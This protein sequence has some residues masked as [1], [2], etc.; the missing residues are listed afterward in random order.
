MIGS[1]PGGAIPL[2]SIDDS[3]TVL[4]V[5]LDDFLHARPDLAAWRHS[6]NRHPAF[7]DA[8]VLTIALMQSDLQVASLKQTY[9]LIAANS[10]AAFPR[11]CSYA[12]WI[13]RVCL[14]HPA[15][16]PAARHHPSHA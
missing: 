5:F 6:P 9:R 14:N 13:A 4:Y 10:R 2:S 11:L 15:H 1:R 8:E 7:S 3:L 16:S 12:R